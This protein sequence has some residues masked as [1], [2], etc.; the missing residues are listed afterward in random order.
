MPSLTQPGVYVDES[1]F[2][3]FVAASPATAVAAFVGYHPKG[4]LA[5][6]V[7][8]SWGLFVANYGGFNQFFPPSDLS[9]AVYSYFNSGGSSCIV[10]RAVSSATPPST[11]RSILAD[12]ETSPAG[13][14][15]VQAI[16]PGAW[17][18]NI[19][20]D[21]TPGQTQDGSGHT[22]TFNLI[23]KYG[24][25]GAQ[26]VV[27]TWNNVTMVA[28]GTTLNQGNNAISVINSINSGSS[29]IT[30]SA[31]TV[32]ATDYTSNPATIAGVQ[33]GT[34]GVSPLAGT[35]G[36]APLA[37]EIQ[38][39][40]QTLDQ[41]PNRPL[42]LNLPNLT[43]TTD[44]GNGI[45]YCEGRGD[46]FLLVD[47]PKGS[48]VTSVTGNGFA[49][50]LSASSY[51]AIY[52]PWIQISDPA[53]PTPGT[54]RLVAPGGFVAGVIVNTDSTRGVSKAP[55]GLQARIPTATG[56][57]L[58]FTNADLGTLNNNNVNAI[59][60]VPKTGIVIMGGRTLSNVLS[61][62]YVNVR[63]SLIYLRTSLLGLTQFAVFEPNGYN[64]WLQLN[65]I[66][67]QFL[68]SFW[69]SGGLQGANAAQAFFIV[70]DDTN[71][72]PNSIAQGI[73]NIQ[74]GVALNAPAEFVVISL[75]QWQGGST[76]TVSA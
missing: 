35:D 25:D 33:I 58:R 74:V 48:S 52:Y 32:P 30:V 66:I 9:L 34:G 51:A 13:S 40:M 15:I 3:S 16:N 43:D 42:I 64:L 72:T 76:T 23:V 5:P 20:V 44:I 41:F 59:Y 73:V 11:A 45:T 62:R 56:T 67:N 29:Y 49:N 55:A 60:S 10:V 7:I 21:V 24:S 50:G 1:A 65:S 6:T 57:E 8:N 68:T 54:T 18:N 37:T 69:M 70:C 28:G 61:T 17:G 2:P 19:F 4:P 22:V 47:P 53:N 39:A 46:C 14:L 71:N 75:G 26:S 63:R 27:E 38:T 31:N 36:N 12:Q